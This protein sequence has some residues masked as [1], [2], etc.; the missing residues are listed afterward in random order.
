M[1]HHHHRLLRSQLKQT[2]ATDRQYGYCPGSTW[3]CLHP[4]DASAYRGPGTGHGFQQ[5]PKWRKPIQNIPA[6]G[7]VGK[8]SNNFNCVSNGASYRLADGG[9]LT[10]I[11]NEHE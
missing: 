2:T 1:N 6:K 7:Y 4:L 10:V 3:V 8:R 5:T 11:I 9:K